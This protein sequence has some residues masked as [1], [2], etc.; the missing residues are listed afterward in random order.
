MDQQHGRISAQRNGRAAR[1]DQQVPSLGINLRPQIATSE[2]NFIF[3]AMSKAKSLAVPDE[4][5][6]NKIYLIREHKV[7]LDR[8]LAELYG[9]KAIRLREQVKRNQERFPDNFMFQLTEKEVEN[10]VS[11]NA[12]PSRQQLGGY[13]PYAF[14]EHGVLMLANVLKSEQAITMSIRIIEIF[15]KLREVLLTHK[16]I[17]LKIEQLERKTVQ[18]DGDIKLI[19][20]YL[21]ELLNP[22]SE[23]M[24]KIGFKQ[25]GK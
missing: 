2:Y 13:L 3:T 9:V 14:T 19:F 20:K 23:P 8:D 4:V 7:M 25:K 11:Q 12:I 10:M 17:L 24:R 16:D 15:V 5:V 21:R 6:M 18:Y 1:G 22:P